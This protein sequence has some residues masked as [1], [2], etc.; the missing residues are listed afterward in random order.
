V[1]AYCDTNTCNYKEAL[2]YAKGITLIPVNTVDD[3]LAALRK[4]K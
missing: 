3:A 2:P 1:P 4:L